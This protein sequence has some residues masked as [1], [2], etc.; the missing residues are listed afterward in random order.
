MDKKFILIILLL[1]M[2]NVI[3][4]N[5]IPQQSLQ[6][7]TSI[8]FEFLDKELEVDYYLPIGNINLGGINP[9]L[10]KTLNIPFKLQYSDYFTRKPDIYFVGIRWWFIGCIS[11]LIII[12]YWV[13]KTRK[14]KVTL[15]RGAT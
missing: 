1:N 4:F 6:Q 14:I 8:D 13:R 7:N 12:V 5:E 2:V 10:T 11:F 9:E 3:A 15:D